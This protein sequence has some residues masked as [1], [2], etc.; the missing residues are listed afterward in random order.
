MARELA[1]AELP[2]IPDNWVLDR[3][4]WTKYHADGRT[5]QV[6]DLG[7]ERMVSFDVETLYK[8]SPYPVMATAASPTAWYSWLSPSIFAT[9]PTEP[10]EERPPWDRRIPDHHPHDLIP[11]FPQ[12]RSEPSGSSKEGPARLVIGHNVGYDRARVLDEYSLKCTG[13]R[14]LDTLSLHVATHG[15]TSVQ[16]PAW[17][18]HRKNKM[19]KREREAEALAVM[20]DTAEEEG[21][22]TLLAQLDAYAGDLALDDIGDEGGN[23]A[24]AA[25]AE[26][27]QKRWEDITSINSL[28]EVASLHCGHK[29]DKSVRNRFADDSIS[30]ASQLVP[31]LSS[32]LAYCAKD[33]KV[34]HDVYQKVFPLF[35]TSCPHPATISGVLSMGNAFLPVDE[36]WEKY[37]QAAETKYREMDE[38]VRKALRVLVEKLR[39]EGRREGDVFMDQLDWTEKKA[40]WSEEVGE[41][42][43][44]EMLGDE[45]QEMPSAQ[46]A[47]GVE[48]GPAALPVADVSTGAAESSQQPPVTDPT[49]VAPNQATTLP[50]WQ[51][52]LADSGYINTPKAAR[53]LL[54]LL[55]RLS[56]LSHPVVHLAEH[57]WCFR[58]P[59]N[60]HHELVNT[61][62]DAVHPGPKD[63][64]VSASG[65]EE[66]HAFF[67][68]DKDTKRVK[69]TGPTM[70]KYVKDGR[71]TAGSV[72]GQEVLQRLMKS[73]T[74]LDEGDVKVLVGELERDRGTIWAKQ[75]DWSVPSECHIWSA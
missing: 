40:R 20:R 62:G 64:L 34:T 38:G 7:G 37:L 46:N 50:A 36:N 74:G 3:P 55:L 44:R 13:T 5:E 67:R 49:S 6:Q 39:K 21:D 68:I 53:T 69:L 24:S 75:L 12:P 25:A 9:A 10:D 4:G 73:G 30:H 18:A 19:Q 59:E 56:Y 72:K 47:L 60:L 22:V 33:V 45:Y 41:R 16:R 54:P 29:V 42:A 51:N 52:P 71:L 11:L 66:E 14:W 31:E 15:I 57:G 43:M 28:A 27:S 23:G 48:G 17:Q 70:G 1:S 65:I 2:P 35:Q 61:H 58:V 26:A 32:L 8:V 63:A